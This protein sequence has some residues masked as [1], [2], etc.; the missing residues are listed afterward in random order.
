MRWVVWIRTLG[1][2][3]QYGAGGRG[4]GGGLGIV[5]PAGMVLRRARFARHFVE[6]NIVVLLKIWEQPVTPTGVSQADLKW[7]SKAGE[8]REKRRSILMGVGGT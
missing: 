2:G 5:G 6:L 1:L 8:G 4:S 3:L 7:G